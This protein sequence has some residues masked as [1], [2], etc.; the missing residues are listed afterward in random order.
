MTCEDDVALLILKERKQLTV[1]I[2]RQACHVLQTIN[3]PFENHLQRFQETVR[4][5]T[6][7]LVERNKVVSRD[8][9]A[10]RR[11]ACKRMTRPNI[12]EGSAT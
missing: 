1:T 7:Q 4:R 2:F 10:S 9:R 6:S 5:P 8:G 3:L 11:S 12:S